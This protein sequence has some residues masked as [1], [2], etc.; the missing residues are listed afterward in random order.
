[1]STV[2]EEIAQAVVSQTILDLKDGDVLIVHVNQDAFLNEPGETE[3]FA[4][5][6]EAFAAAFQKA[7]HENIGCLIIAAAGME[8]V[9]RI[10]TIRP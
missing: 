1:M 8:P 5:I 3:A 10:E 9:L 2:T 7:G 4:E 6:R